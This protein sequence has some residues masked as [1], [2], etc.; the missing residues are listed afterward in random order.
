[1][2]EVEKNE[3][4]R[5]AH[6]FKGI[7]DSMVI[8][9]LQGYMG[10]AYADRLPNP[11]V[12]MIV[13]GEYSF[14]AG[15][16]DSEAARKLAQNVFEYIEESSSVAMYADDDLRWRDLL[17]SVPENNAQEVM[18]YGI[19]QKNYEF[20]RKKLQAFIDGLPED[21]S[22]KRFDR[23]MYDEAMSADWS[24]EFCETFPSAE[25]YLKR[26]FGFG[27]VYQDHLVSGA[28][29]MTVYDG[30]TEIQIA[31]K[32][33]FRQKGLAMPCAAAMLRECMDRKIRPC[34][35]AATL[36]SKHMALKLGYEYKGEYSTVHMHK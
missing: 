6:L 32:D 34:W 8:S 27:A 14:F 22:L 9:C 33:E 23:Q 18:R 10:K 13:S 7:E 4:Y 2:I 3:M 20:D 26:G 5:I 15:D 31:T 36:V 29:T 25:D 12:S 17:L 21:F 16:A 24:K 19:V 35:D 11:T 1:M 30:G 28:S